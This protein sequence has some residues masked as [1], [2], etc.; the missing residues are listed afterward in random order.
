MFTNLGLHGIYSAMDLSF[1]LLSLWSLLSIL[2]VSEDSDSLDFMAMRKAKPKR[3]LGT[4]SQ[5]GLITVTNNLI[6][7][8]RNASSGQTCILM[9]ILKTNQ[10]P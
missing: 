6:P 10:I 1:W 2:C 4:N 8:L 5:S 9:L 3:S 7:C